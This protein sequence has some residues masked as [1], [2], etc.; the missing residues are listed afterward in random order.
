MMA[1]ASL[2]DVRRVLLVNPH[3]SS[4]RRQG[5]GQYRRVWQPLELA[6]A[7]RLLEQDGYCVSL[8]DN[9]VERRSVTEL[10]SLAGGHDVTFVTS[11]PY[12]R[13]QCP[14]LDISYFYEAISEMPKDKLVVLGPHASERPHQVLSGTG[15]SAAVLH[16]PEETILDICRN[17]LRAGQPGVARLDGETLVQGAAVAP[18]D[19]ERAPFPAFHHLSMSS[20]YYELMGRDFA[21]LEASRGCPYRCTFCYLGMYGQIFRQKSPERFCAEV[22]WTARTHGCRNFYFMDLEFALRRR[23][24]EAF[25]ELLLRRKVNVNWCCQTRVTDVDD[26]LVGLMARAGC[27]LIHFGVESGSARI[28]AKTG[29][30]IQLEDAQRAVSA[31]RRHGIASAVFM[32]LGFP[33]ETAS[34][35]R[36]TRAFARSLDPTYASFH[37]VTPYPG[38]PLAREVPSHDLPWHLYPA[39]T[40]TSDR[41]F[42]L[43]KQQLRLAYASFYLRPRALWR[44]C[45]SSDVSMLWSKGR[46]V[47]DLV[48][49]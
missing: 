49:Q 25:C 31:T 7:A 21:L 48:F 45:A 23:F 28:L 16:E 43:L 15:A 24:V 10:G 46:V 26:S 37:L 34:E 39:S 1:S 17:G 9:N 40:A 32:N 4:L 38:T 18:M 19:L 41:E 8:V 11:S 20:Y 2:R 5:Q 14:A 3:W 35:R 44:M 30:K 42:H 12:D 47:L 29:K 27:K 36:E 33:G 22:E 6:M 13:W